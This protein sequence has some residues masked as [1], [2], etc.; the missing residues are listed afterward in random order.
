MAYCPE[1]DTII[2]FSGYDKARDEV[3]RYIP[4]SDMWEYSFAANT[5]RSVAQ[6]NPP[7]ARLHA[8]LTVYPSAD[9]TTCTAVLVGGAILLS[10]TPDALLS[11]DDVWLLQLDSHQANWTQLSVSQAN[12]GARAL[13]R[14]VYRRGQLV[15]VGG[16]RFVSPLYLAFNDVWQFDLALP[17][18]NS[19][20]FPPSIWSRISPS[21][22]TQ[23]WLTERFAFA[24]GLSLGAVPA[25]DR[26]VVFGGLSYVN[27]LDLNPMGDLSIYNFGTNSWTFP[28]G[29]QLNRASHHGF[30]VQGRFFAFA[31]RTVLRSS[32]NVLRTFVFQSLLV[33]DLLANPTVQGAAPSCTTSDGSTGLWCASFVRREDVRP[34]VRYDY[35]FAQRQDQMIVYG[36]LFKAPMEDLWALNVSG[37]LAGLV[38]ADPDNLEGLGDLASTVYFMI[39]ILAMMVVCFMV[40]V[41]SLKRHRQGQTMFVVGMAHV[42]NRQVGARS[43]FVESLPLRKYHKGGNVATASG[44][45][46][47]KG[48]SGEP[49]QVVMIQEDDLHG[50]CAI[51]LNDYEEGE[52]IRV[53]PCGHFFHPT[54]VGQWLTNHNACPMCKS[55]VDPEPQLDS[56]SAAETSVVVTPGQGEAPNTPGVPPAAPEHAPSESTNATA[57]ATPSPQGAASTRFDASAN[58]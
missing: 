45:A 2:L 12:P 9:N 11:T 38:I 55:A 26:L 48:A 27:G 56:N 32:N 1:R 36:G 58:V 7:S 24:M 3:E 16:M 54:C 29:L 35:S 43:S 41:I 44:E 22:V 13:H 50:M 52:S 23:P 33:T 57:E 30:V 4:K 18:A 49:V 34:Y 5:W 47:A 46:D 25:G 20:T 19:T 31:G 14:A 17:P 6:V 10:N 28:Q 39:A 40:F 8:S 51:C 21:S 53:L 42:P 37:A 15:M